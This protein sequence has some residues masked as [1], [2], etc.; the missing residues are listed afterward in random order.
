MR[1]V[2]FKSDGKSRVGA[3]DLENQTLVFNAEL[4][5]SLLELI[6]TDQWMGLDSPN[7]DGNQQIDLG[8]V[9]LLAPIVGMEKVICIGVNYADH[10]REM[11]GEPPELP[12]VFN[13]FPS[14]IIANNAEIRLPSISSKVDFEAEL[15]VVIGKR[16]KHIARETAMDHV[17][18]Y[19]CGNDIS[20]RDWQK[21]RPGGQWLLGKTFDTFG[22]LGPVIAT[23]DEISDPHRLAIQSRLNGNVMQDSN[24][25]QLIFPIDYLI[26]HISQFVTLKPG[27]LLFTGTPPGVGAG[28][29]PPIFLKPGDELEVEVE[30]LGVL[31]NRVVADR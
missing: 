10:A 26:S 15:V 25:D 6:Q 9:E 27:D 30:G 16:G 22:P 20:A 19:C 31:K 7:G 24:T 4:A 8:D 3:V 17:F 12:V 23:R 2:S 5:G 29:N 14:T 13:K 28:R 18:G 21:G 11:G 1:L